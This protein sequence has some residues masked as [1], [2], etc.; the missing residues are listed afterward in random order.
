[1]RWL[2]APVLP[3]SRGIERRS[4]FKDDSDR[5]RFFEKLGEVLAGTLIPLV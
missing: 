3:R 2:G 4:I 1:L 5:E